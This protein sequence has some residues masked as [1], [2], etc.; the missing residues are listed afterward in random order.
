[1]PMLPLLKGDEETLKQIFYFSI[2]LFAASLTP[3]LANAGILYFV[4]AFFAGI[5]FLIKTLVA[6]RTKKTRDIWGVFGYSII[7]LFV[8]LSAIIVDSLVTIVV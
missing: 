8:I 1:L 3:L 2:L 5:L 7:Y 6:K 4:V